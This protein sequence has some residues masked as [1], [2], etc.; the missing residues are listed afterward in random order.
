VDNGIRL[1]V[2]HEGDAGEKGGVRGDLYVSIHVREHEFFKRHNNHIYCEIKIS[3]TQAVFGS[4]IDVPTVDG[5][6][7]LKIPA[8]TESGKVFRLRGKGMPAIFYTS[9]KGDQLVRI[10]VDVPKR[11]TEEQKKILKEYASTLGEKIV[12]K[13]GFIEKVKKAFK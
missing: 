13:K 11:L 1:R 8:G 2:P 9:E 5:K 10:S 6:T 7:K 4:E 12:P 3:F